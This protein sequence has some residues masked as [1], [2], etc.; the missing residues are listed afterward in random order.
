[1]IK[2]ETDVDIRVMFRIRSDRAALMK[3]GDMTN[4]TVRNQP[5]G[6]VKIVAVEQTPVKVTLPV[7]G[8]PQAVKDESEFNVQ[9]YAVTLRDHAVISE[10]GYVAEGVKLKIGLPMNLEGF[11]YIVHGGIV[12]VQPV[13]NHTSKPLDSHE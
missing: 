11:D 4:I 1:M 13:S 6:E 12:D 5:R 7:N 9:E 3:A 10:E 2:G 8:V